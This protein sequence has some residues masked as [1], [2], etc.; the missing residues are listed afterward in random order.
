MLNIEK[1][2]SG[3]NLVYIIKEYR[4]KGLFDT[5]LSNCNFFR[6]VNRE[7]LCWGQPY[8][9]FRDVIETDSENERLGFFDAGRYS[10]TELNEHWRINKALLEDSIRQISRYVVEGQHGIENGNIKP[11]FSILNFFSDNQIQEHII[12]D[13]FLHT[14]M[15]PILDYDKPKIEDEII[16]Q[17]AD[18]FLQLYSEQL[19]LIQ[20]YLRI[21]KE[22]LV[23]HFDSNPDN[24]RTNAD[25][26]PVV[27]SDLDTSFQTFEIHSFIKLTHPGFPWNLFPNHIKTSLKER[28]DVF[29][30][31]LSFSQ[32]Q[33][34]RARAVI[35]DNETLVEDIDEFLKD[36]NIF[37]RKLSDHE[38]FFTFIPRERNIDFMQIAYINSLVHD[39]YEIGNKTKKLAETQDK[40]YKRKLNKER[41]YHA[42]TLKTFAQLLRLT[43]PIEEKRLI[44][45]SVREIAGLFSEI[46]TSE[47]QDH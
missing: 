44:F 22:G 17:I 32:L 27:L 5:E 47:F 40:E 8:I 31:I 28:P 13:E 6:E 7:R 23:Y 2:A 9:S 29:Y 36:K 15:N 3:R 34:K 20:H 21:Y 35:H 1:A 30:N 33:L 39:F 11:K 14:I 26:D 37:E 16:Y 42:K 18:V 4:N 41:K 10:L 19:K 25:V 43:Y 38:E 24:I 12:Y 46:F 45:R